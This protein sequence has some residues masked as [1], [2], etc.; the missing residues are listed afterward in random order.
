MRAR[1][2]A[3][4]LREPTAIKDRHTDVEENQGRRDLRSQG[5]G[6]LAIGRGP[7]GISFIGQELADNLP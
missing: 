2:L 3:V 6:S 5:E 7:D 1:H 4:G